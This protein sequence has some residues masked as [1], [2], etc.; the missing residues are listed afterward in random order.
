MSSQRL[1]LIGS[2]NLRLAG[3]GGLWPHPLRP[4][5]AT[6]PEGGACRPRHEWD[7]AAGV[8]GRGPSLGLTAPWEPGDGAMCL[9]Y[10]AGIDSLSGSLQAAIKI[11]R[12]LMHSFISTVGSDVRNGVLSGEGGGAGE[13]ETVFFQG[14]FWR[15]ERMREAL[16]QRPAVRQVSLV[17]AAAGEPP[18]LK[19][20]NK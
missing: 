14:L 6:R 17:R 7:V 1:P 10:T 9:G 20:G 11:K 16:R 5:W 19:H 3:A 18:R 15:T 4:G 12:F 13:G 8:S 2:S